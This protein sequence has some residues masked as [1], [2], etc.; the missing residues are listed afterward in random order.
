M[1]QGI[2]NPSDI[3]CDLYVGSSTKDVNPLTR[4]CAGAGALSSGSDW[5]VLTNWTV[6]MT[7]YSDEYCSVANGQTKNFTMSQPLDLYHEV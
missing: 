5:D 7:F 6:R 3:Q 4:P 2:S 1:R